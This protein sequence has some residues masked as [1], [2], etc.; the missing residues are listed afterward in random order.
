MEQLSTTSELTLEVAL[1]LG[2]N[3]VRT[4]AMSSTDGVKRGLEVEN[5]ED[6]FL[7]QLEML[8]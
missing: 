6:Q 5:K 3:T 8:H 7:F 4:I 1:H 2:D